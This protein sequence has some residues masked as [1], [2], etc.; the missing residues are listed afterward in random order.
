MTWTRSASHSSRVIP[1][2]FVS[3][4]VACLLGGGDSSLHESQRQLDSLGFGQ[5]KISRLAGLVWLVAHGGLIALLVERLDFGLDRLQ[6]L[7]HS[8]SFG[9]G[10][11]AKRIAFCSASASSVMMRWS[12]RSQSCGFSDVPTRTPSA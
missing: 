9:A 4:I 10:E 11:R 5:Q 2:T 1:P 12:T 6:F 3:L 7:A 8:P